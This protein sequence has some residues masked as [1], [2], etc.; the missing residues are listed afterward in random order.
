MRASYIA[1]NAK[2]I[3]I[4]RS[5]GLLLDSLLVLLGFFHF[6]FTDFIAFAHE[7]LL[8]NEMFEG[9]MVMAGLLE[10]TRASSP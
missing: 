10:V 7:R 1:W 2:E 9:A 6:A 8:L 4:R 3:K 5:G